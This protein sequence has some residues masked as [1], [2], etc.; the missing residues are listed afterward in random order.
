MVDV[1]VDGDVV[2]QGFGFAL[3][4]EAARVKTLRHQRAVAH[5]QEISRGCVDGLGIVAQEEFALFGIERRQIL[6]A[7][8]A[9]RTVDEV[10]KVV[11]VGKEIG[12]AMGNLLGVQC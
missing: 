9:R 8:R 6:A 4:C 7:L 5:K 10:E 2:G 12:P 1:S 3:Q 11:A